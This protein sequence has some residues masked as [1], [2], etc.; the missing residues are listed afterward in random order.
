MQCGI[1]RTGKLFAY[2]WSNIKPDLL[3]SAKGLGGGFPIGAV[4][5][6]NKVAKKTKLVALCQVLRDGF[7]GLG[8][9]VGGE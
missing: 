6:T 1:G 3:T 8:G 7:R 4:L 9:G 5:M 2:Q